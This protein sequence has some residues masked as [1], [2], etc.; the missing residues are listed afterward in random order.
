M[1]KRIRS[2]NLDTAVVENTD[3]VMQGTIAY[4]LLDAK[5]TFKVNIDK[6]VKNKAIIDTIKKEYN[7]K[8]N[9]DVLLAIHPLLSDDLRKKIKAGYNKIYDKIDRI[10]EMERFA[11]EVEELENAKKI[12]D[13]VDDVVDDVVADE[14]DDVV[15]VM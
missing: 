12:A 5:K 2:K 4:T 9:N 6:D 10:E 1:S 11:K 13:V 8:S 7:L 15:D 3:F 14:V